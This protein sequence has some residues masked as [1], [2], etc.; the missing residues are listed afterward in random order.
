MIIKTYIKHWTD[1][2][3]L[4]KILHTSSARPFGLPRFL[5]AEETLRSRPLDCYQI[6]TDINAAMLEGDFYD[7]LIDAISKSPYYSLALARKF[8]H[9]VDRLE[10]IIMQCPEAAAEYATELI[11][12][13]W[14][15]AEAAI[16]TCPRA[17]YKYM[18]G[19]MKKHWP[20][21]YQVLKQDQFYLDKYHRIA[22]D[23]GMFIIS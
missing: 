22:S 8:R 1:E 3:T 12:R 15:E 7:T 19:T 2:A 11:K 17:T 20:E 4:M 6:A 5:T 13:P 18:T 23:C 21:G 14:P 10:P 16:L 9:R